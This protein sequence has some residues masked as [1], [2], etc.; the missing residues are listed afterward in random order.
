MRTSDEARE[1][2]TGVLLVFLAALKASD[3]GTHGVVYDEPRRVSSID[4]AW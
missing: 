1:G 4:L 3:S 2:D